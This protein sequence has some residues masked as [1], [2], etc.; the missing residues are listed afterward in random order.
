[1]RKMVEKIEK[2]RGNYFFLVGMGE[3]SGKSKEDEN[4]LENRENSDNRNIQI[5]SEYIEENPR[6]LPTKINR[7]FA[8][9]KSITKANFHYIIY[10]SKRIKISIDF[11]FH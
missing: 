8:S 5:N 2:G 10:N 3:N 1:M 4:V 9:I 7:K 11:H 6:E